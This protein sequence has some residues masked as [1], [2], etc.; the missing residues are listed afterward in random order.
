MPRYTYHCEKCEN[1]YDVSHAMTERVELQ[2]VECE[3]SLVKVPSV[4]LSLKVREMDSKTGEVVKSSIE[5]FRKDLKDQRA[6]ASK[7]EV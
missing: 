7:K 1:Y 5:E 2:C 6:E 3:E 4:P